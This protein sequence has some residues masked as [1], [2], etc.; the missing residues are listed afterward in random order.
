MT[1][2]DIT[3][4]VLLTGPTRGIGRAML[5]RLLT[6]PAQPRLVL[7]ARDRGSLDEAVAAA[8]AAG[9][10]A[11]G[12]LLDLADLDSVRSALE[13]VA[14][15]VRSGEVATIDAALLNAGGQF[16]DR[17]HVS[18]QGHELTFAINVVAQ[19]AVLQGLV[20][21]LS[22]TGHVVLA[23]S[24]THRGKRQS[25]GLVPDPF[26]QEPAELAIPDDTPPGTFRAERERGGVA[27]ATSK[28]ALVT[29]SHPWATRL[30]STGR[31]LNV[32]DPGL[33]AGTGLVR[34]MPAYMDWVWRNVMPA[35]AVLPGA[36]TPRGTARHAVALALGERHRDRHDAYIEIGRETRAEAVTFD[37]GRQSRLWAWLQ[38]AT[39]TVGHPDIPMVDRELPEG[40]GGMPGESTH[41]PIGQ[42]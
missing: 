14:A 24:S 21:L 5:H 9:A 11:R 35:M 33:V 32:Y 2:S 31:R 40:D 38:D 23:G 41:H 37:A 17:R 8:R 22:P 27:Y 1:Q 28:L 25:F 16:L 6:H 15:L 42:R 3:P 4:T 26:W 39:G 12:I 34:G 7:L 18:A 10:D 20:P 13:K 19:H 36:T 29:L 30:G